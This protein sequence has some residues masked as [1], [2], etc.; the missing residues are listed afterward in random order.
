MDEWAAEGQGI[1]AVLN[2]NISSWSIKT[3][4]G[5]VSHLWSN[6]YNFLLY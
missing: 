4:Y 3:Q 6:V 5:I 2:V 1:I